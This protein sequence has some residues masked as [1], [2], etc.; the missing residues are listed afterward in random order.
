MLRSKLDPN[1]RSIWQKMHIDLPLLLGLLTL[2]G[3]GLFVIYSAGGRDWDL[4]ERQLIRLAL[5]L[6]VMLA[7]AQVPPLA[8]RRLSVHFYVVGILMLVAVLVMGTVGKGAQRWLD[9]GFMRFQPSE[10]MKLAVPMMMAWYISRFNLPPRLLHIIGGFLL[11]VAPTLLI[12]KQPDL[13]TSLLIASSGLFVLFL[14]GMSWKLIGSVAILGSAFAPVMWFFLMKDYQKQRV[15]TFLNPESDP[16]GSGYHIIQSKIAIGSG[17][18]S[19]KGWLHGTQSQLEFLPERHTDFIFA[20]FSE[21]FGFTGILLLLVLYCFI[22]V[23]GMII[24]TRAQEAYSKLLAGSLT[25]TFF[26]YVFVNM[27][28][29]SGILPVVG[30]PLPLVSYG[31]TS[32][33]TLLAG[34]GML[35]AIGTQRRLL[36][37]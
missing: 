8:Y 11:L 21:E 28:M 14:A 25:L 18:F 2:M 15:L 34:F 36:S 17:G 26:V 10:I 24:A 37:R 1:K 23:R 16:L 32:M 13:G 5:A 6:T 19:G 3:V 9:L 35:M 4:I 20:V 12:A 30:V 31:G 7:V 22:I 33:V 27:G 29:V